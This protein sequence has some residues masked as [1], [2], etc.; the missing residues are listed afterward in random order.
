MRLNKSIL[1]L[2]LGFLT[3][4]AGTALASTPDGQTPSEETIC[5]SETGAGY[6]LC[7][8]YCEAMDC[9]SP[10]PHASLTGCSRVKANFQR[11]TG[12]PLPCDVVCPCRSQFPLFGDIVNGTPPPPQQ[13]LIDS[14]QVSVAL[15]DGSFALV[16]ST[17]SAFCS[18]NNGAPL[19]LTAAEAL[20]CRDL[21]R[22]AAAAAGVAC[23]SPE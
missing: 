5:D 10:A 3:I 13:C 18:V 6:G 9:D 14:S 7:T 19:I 20:V 17:A 11:I 21:L 2:S 16:N 4:S 23:V 12:R 22:K 8:A 15:P 1:I